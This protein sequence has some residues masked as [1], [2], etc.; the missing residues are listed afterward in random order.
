MAELR[1]LLSGLGYGD[2]ATLL[3]S[4]NAVFTAGRAPSARYAVEIAAAL[5]ARLHL[6]VRVIVKSAAEFAAVTKENPF[7]AT[8]E[9]PSRILVAFTQDPAAL[10]GLAPLAALATPPD[11]F[12]VGKHAAFLRCPRGSLES[13]V[14]EALL[15]RAGRAA[16]TRNWATTLKLQ[17]LLRERDLVSRSRPKRVTR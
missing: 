5:S 15:G 16:T 17:A 14:G 1:A 4:G 11:E 8:A 2:V 9:D 12:A 10:Q 6:D 7:A 13:R 3:N